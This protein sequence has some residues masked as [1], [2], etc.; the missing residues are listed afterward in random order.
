MKRRT[1]L[2]L[3]LAAS[4]FAA[5]L[6]TAA[7]LLDRFV[8]VTGGTQAYAAHKSEI[9]RGTVEMA[10]MGIKGTVTRYTAE[11][12]R[13]LLIM[14]IPGIGRVSTGVKDGIAWE[15]SELMGSRIKSGAERAEA[16]REA[17]F[18]ANT[19]WRELYPKVETTGE[20]SVDGEE[21]YKVVMTPAEGSPETLFLSKKSG[22]AVKMTAIASTQ[23]GDIPA[24]IGLSGY[25]DFGGVLVPT[26]MTQKTGGQEIVMTLQ[27]VE[28]NP[29]IPASQF[30]VPADLAGRN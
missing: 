1:I 19:A 8:Q 17:R 22:L 2:G 24:E 5:D 6:P 25:K 18:N 28:T 12:D 27:S 26:R 3:L 30:D 21:C 16:L 11:P 14:E 4:A 9:A 23:M 29:A 13:Y 20:E 7:S 15:S 10:A